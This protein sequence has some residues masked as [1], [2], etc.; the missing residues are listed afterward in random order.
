MRARTMKTKAR[1]GPATQTQFALALRPFERVS[2]LL[3]RR[4]L[5][6]IFLTLLFICGS[7]FDMKRLRISL[8]VHEATL[9]PLNTPLYPFEIC[10]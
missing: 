6:L 3:E 1:P 4:L 9:D 7:I 5:N 10:N 8:W 2:I